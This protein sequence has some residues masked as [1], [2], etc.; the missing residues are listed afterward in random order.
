MHL[1]K[2]PY[3]TFPP[4]FPVYQ[5]CFHVILTPWIGLRTVQESAKQTSRGSGGTITRPPPSF[6]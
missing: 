2:F 4:D 1:Q 3:V 5:H 6:T